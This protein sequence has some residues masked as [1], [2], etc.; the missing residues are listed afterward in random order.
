MTEQQKQQIEKL[1]RDGY[2]YIKIA[3]ALGV[4]Q[5]TV[6]SY[7][8][9]KNLT[10]S[11]GTQQPKMRM[12]S[13]DGEHF[14][15]CCGTPVVQNPGRKVKKFCSDICRNKWWNHNLDKVNRKANYDFICPHCKKP[16]TV[17]GNA[18][19]KYCSHECY[20]A[21]RFGGGLYD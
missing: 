10:G 7:C 3:Q 19:R 13:D 1:R 5:N 18:N 21:D 8:R 14:C 12:P 16:F 20:V 11:L 2:G 6:K 17:Y 9:R 15:L 4:S